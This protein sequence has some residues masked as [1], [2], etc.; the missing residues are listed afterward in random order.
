MVPVN[1]PSPPIVKRVG[2]PATG[3]I[4]TPLS[5]N[6]C[7]SRVSVR[8]ATVKVEALIGSLKTTGTEATG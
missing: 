2:S 6:G 7:P 1:A 5:V 3:A 8:S 4:V